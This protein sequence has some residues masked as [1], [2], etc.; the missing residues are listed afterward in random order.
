MSANA[1]YTDL[2]DL[3][4]RILMCRV[5]TKRRVT[6]FVGYIRFC[7]NKG[8]THLDLGCGTG[9]HVRHFIDYGY[10]S[11]GLDLNKPM[12][13]INS[14]SFALK[15]TSQCKVCCGNWSL[16]EPLDLITCF[17][18]SIHYNDGLEKLKK[19]ALQACTG[20]KPEE[21]VSASR[22]DATKR[23]SAMTCL[24]DTR[25][26]KFQM[27][28]H[29]AQVGITP[30][31]VASKR[32]NSALKRQQRSETQIWNDEHPRWSRSRSKID[33]NTEALLQGSY[34]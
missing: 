13:D 31:K 21:C 30:E 1:L 25:P 24:F 29:F 20:M 28:S 26:T 16:W 6:A 4:W 7:G 8:K 34:L 9:P 27:I 22:R 23:K 3:L 19:S 14:S 5:A 33:W 17:L 18:Y 12:L 2:S 10:Q 15:P 32:W 11:N